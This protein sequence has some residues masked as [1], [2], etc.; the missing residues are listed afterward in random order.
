M[1][2]RLLVS[3]IAEE[4]SM[5]RAEAARALETFLR[6]VQSSLV[7]GERVTLAGFGTFGI[8]Q[9]KAR[10]VRDPRRGTTMRIEARR[11]ARFAA[12]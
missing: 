5:T 3:Q 8:S 4:T 9:H 10:L 7:R 2:K 11:V 12:G 6:A 1:N